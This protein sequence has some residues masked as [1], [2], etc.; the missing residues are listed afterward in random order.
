MAEELPRAGDAD[1]ERALANLRTHLVYRP[2]QDFTEGVLRGIIG[3]AFA[4]LVL[5]QDPQQ[6]FLTN[7]VVRDEQTLDVKVQPH[8]TKADVQRLLVALAEG[9]ARIFPGKSLTLLAFYRSGDKLAEANYDPRTNRVDVQF[10]Q[11]Q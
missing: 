7:A 2:V 5:E 11:G 9:M 6:Q 1:L 8:V 4:R 10:V 3:V